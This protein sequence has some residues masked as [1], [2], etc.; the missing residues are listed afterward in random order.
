MSFAQG[1]QLTYQYPGPSAKCRRRKAISWLVSTL[2][3]GLTVCGVLG[4]LPPDGVD[5]V[6][7]VGRELGGLSRKL[8]L[9]LGDA[10]GIVLRGLGD[11]IVVT[12]GIDVLLFLV[13]GDVSCV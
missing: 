2:L 5:S 6:D 1:G 11:G 13:E 9:L 12:F 3:S 8:M 7:S 4:V 10:D